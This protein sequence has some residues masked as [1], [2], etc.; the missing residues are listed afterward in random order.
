MPFLI[1]L[2]VAPSGDVSCSIGR[3]GRVPVTQTVPAQQVASLCDISTLCTPPAFLIPG[4]DLDQLEDEEEWGRRASALLFGAPQLAAMLGRALSSTAKPTPL[5]LRCADDRLADLPW[6]LLTDPA[7]GSG[8][9]RS[10]QGTVSRLVPAPFVR[11]PPPPG[12]RIRVLTWAPAVDD[13]AIKDLL[14]ALD[15]TDRDT[16]CWHRLTDALQELPPPVPGTVDILHL[17]F[18]GRREFGRLRLMLGSG[19]RAGETTRGLQPLLQRCALVLLDVCHGGMSVG[20]ALGGLGRELV[21]AGAGACVATGAEVAVDAA[22][23]FTRGLLSSLA[24]GATLVE[25]TSEGRRRVA[26]QAIGHPNARWHNHR[27]L[28]ADT[29]WL[30]ASLVE[31][32]GW[33][34]GELPAGL[35]PARDLWACLRLEAQRQG[36]LGIEALARA[37]VKQSHVSPSGA[38]VSTTEVLEFSVAGLSR[39]TQSDTLPTTPRLAELLASLRHVRHEQDLHERLEQALC[40]AV[41]PRFL[42]PVPADPPTAMVLE[43]VGGPECGRRLHLQVGDRLARWFPGSAEADAV[44]LFRQTVASDLTI[45]RKGVATVL[46]PGVLAAL[47]RPIWVQRWGGVS[48]ST[49]GTRDFTDGG[50]RVV[51]VSAGRSTEVCVG[52]EIWLSARPRPGSAVGLGPVTRVRVRAVSSPRSS[53]GNPAPSA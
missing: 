52:D 19:S 46:A 38:L 14:Q 27:L 18:H 25:A 35:P 53:S 21:G 7:N 34:P 17:A 5:V 33:E 40:D 9:E 30:S 39:A 50:A 43:V 24:E 22:A 23:A 37:L 31:V 47:R 49:H 1:T 10:G 41:E 42:A 13:P 36:F 32:R 51:E 15:P 2:T 4:E 3:V 48:A 12:Q 44:H 29:A 16:L 45:S 6:E 20:G 11:S 28:V 26:M 8:L